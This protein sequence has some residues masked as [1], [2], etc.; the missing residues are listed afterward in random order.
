MGDQ[1]SNK[2]AQNATDKKT[3]GAR[4]NFQGDNNHSVNKVKGHSFNEDTPRNAE[5]HD[6]LIAPIMSGGVKHWELINNCR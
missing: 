6:P 3:N 5:T 1:S 2:R 4:I